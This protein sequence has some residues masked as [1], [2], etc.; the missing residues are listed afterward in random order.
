MIPFKSR[1]RSVI[2]ETYT[3]NKSSILRQSSLLLS[4]YEG[5][6]TNKGSLKSRNVGEIE[7]G[8]QQLSESIALNYQRSQSV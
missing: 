8:T 7:S 1:N 2:K 3:D 4:T 5:S 6:S